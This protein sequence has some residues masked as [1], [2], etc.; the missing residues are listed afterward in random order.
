VHTTE[1]RK[2]QNTPVIWMSSVLLNLFVLQYQ[3]LYPVVPPAEMS[4]SN[5]SPR[6]SSSQLTVTGWRIAPHVP[7]MIIHMH[8]VTHSKTHTHTHTHSDTHTPHTH[9]H[10][11]I[12]SVE[13]RPLFWFEKKI[14]LSVS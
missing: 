14:E 10:T 13:N 5:E 9:T 4:V 12:L 1:Q 2:Q 3:E 7:L 8:T 6:D 11:T